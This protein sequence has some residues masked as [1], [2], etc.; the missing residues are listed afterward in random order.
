MKPNGPGFPL[1]N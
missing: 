1:N